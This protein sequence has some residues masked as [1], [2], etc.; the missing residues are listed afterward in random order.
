MKCCGPMRAPLPPVSRQCPR[1][2]QTTSP[3][4]GK[5]PRYCGVCGYRLDRPPARVRHSFSSGSG[6][7]AGKAVAS[8][9]LAILSFVPTCI[10]LL[11]AVLAL[12]LA[13][14]AAKDFRESPQ[15]IG[16]R[17]MATIAMTLSIIALILHLLV[18]VGH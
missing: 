10:G 16:G 2:S 9:C 18:Y 17:G 5:T 8:M 11:A 14:S 13:L 6:R 12:G 4:G 1:C 7:V 3:R 15:Q